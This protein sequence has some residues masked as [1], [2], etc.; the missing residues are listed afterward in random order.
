[1]DITKIRRRLT[2]SAAA[3]AVLPLV[4]LSSGQANA[5]TT[6]TQSYGLWWSFNSPPPPNGADRC[7]SIE[8][9]GTFTWN[10][11]SFSGSNG[12]NYYEWSNIH[13]SN[14]TIQI[15]VYSGNPYCY[16]SNAKLSNATLR[17]AWT[18][19]A[20]SDN[21]SISVAFPWSIGFSFWP[22]CGSRKQGFRS[23]YFP[24]SLQT[25]TQNNSGDPIG[26]GAQYY[27]GYSPPSGCSPEFGTF[28]TITVDVSGH[29]D[30]YN[31]GSQSACLR[32]H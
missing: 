22:S 18:G 6:Y 29:G 26:F 12:L 7:I 23:Q 28:P 24:D 2:L 21:P 19:Y 20:C 8:E 4:T 13:I 3:L 16:D 5:A 31:G 32:W 30:T 15:W 17:Q 25:Y 1:M 10:N 27:I 14:P 9:R 11:S